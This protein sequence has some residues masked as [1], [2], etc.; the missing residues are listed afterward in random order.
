MGIHPG[1]PARYDIID[2]VK[3]MLVRLENGPRHGRVRRNKVLFCT[4]EFFPQLPMTPD[5]FAL[6]KRKARDVFQ[7]PAAFFR[8]IENRPQLSKV[9][10]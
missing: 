4:F 8:T 10:A 7:R 5:P 9:S 1:I 2:T 6:I 3:L